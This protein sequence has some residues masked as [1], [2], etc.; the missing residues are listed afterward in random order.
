MA[1]DGFFL[2]CIKNEIAAFAIGA[3][4][5]KIFLPTRYELVLSLR[6]RTEQK[7]L[8]ISVAGN[9]PRINFT[10]YSPENPA[11]P[12]MLCMLLRKQLTGAVIT[13][14]RQAG[15][16]RILFIDFDATD[17]IGERVKR[18]L[19]VEIMAQYSNC[20]LIDENGYVIDALK[21]V[22][23][24]KSSFR[25][26]LP[27]CEYVMPPQQDK[28]SIGEASSSAIADKVFALQSEKLS[29]AVLQVL[30]GASPLVCRELAYRV[31]LSDP[32]VSDLNE[33][34]KDRFIHE[35][36]ILK[37]VLLNVK[38]SPCY[39]TDADGN[40][41][42]FSFMPLTL[43]ANDAKLIKT[44]T[45]SQIPDIFYV[46]REKLQRAHS[47]AEDLFRLVSSLVERTVKKLNIQREELAEDEKTDYKRVYAE[48]INA[49]LYALKK[50]ESEYMVADYYND[51]QP[52]KIPVDPALSPAQNAQK[53][54]KEYRKAQTAKKVLREQIEIGMND[55][56]YLKS[57]QDELSRAETEKELSAIR[58]ELG[59]SGYLKSKTGTQNKKNAPLPPLEFN[60]PDGFKLIVGRNNIQND[61]ISF[62]KAHKSDM[63]FH[64]KNAPG[65]H[66]VLL[67]DG[68]KPPDRA[69]EFAAETA[70]YYSSVRER[71]MAEVDYTLIKN[72]KKPPA[73]KPGFVIYHVYNTAYVKAADPLKNEKINTES[74]SDV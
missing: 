51:Y 14:I 15:F 41:R 13:G 34:Q 18:T 44:E 58:Q 35:I 57:V 60:A 49:N 47:K 42:E 46:E 63:W 10:S 61:N 33:G 38:V 67:T 48:L 43:F 9:S 64:V 27:K 52:V 8:F 5:D 29:K 62:K 40:Y 6:T 28:L 74:E 3:K 56:E 11:K 31:T 26:V 73:A 21:R 66:A 1:F 30:S 16:D 7:K 2:H 45:L 69:M 39:L 37:D 24:S 55:L 17:D 20:I 23:A 68:A 32:L 70:A 65:S 22:D 4:V 59:E 36:E 71:G 25:V 72:L 50:G 19:A 54:F 12:P 53:Y